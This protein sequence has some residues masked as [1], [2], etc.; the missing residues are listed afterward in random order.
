MNVTAR[1]IHLTEAGRVPDSLVRAGIRRLLRER[2]ASLPR[3]DREVL[4]DYRRGFIARMDA[5]PLAVMTDAA[6]EQHY[7]VPSDYYSLVLGPR[8]KYSSCHWGEGVATLEDAEQAALAITC[9]RAGLADGQRILELGCGW[10]SLSL[11]MAERYP[12]A[13]ITAVSNSHSQRA[14]IEARATA[15]GLAN[16]RVITADMNGFEPQG[17]FDRIVSV[18]MFEHMRNWRTLFARVADWLD[19][20]GRFFMH[21]FCHRDSPYFFEEESESDWMTR[22]FFRGGMMPSAD[23]PLHFQQHLTLLDQW[24]WNGIHYA[25]TLEAWL[26]RQDASEDAVLAVLAGHHGAEAPLWVTRWR[27]FYLACAEL[28]RMNGGNEWF[29]GHYLFEKPGARGGGRE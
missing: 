16:L 13:A 8:R 12:G 5:S 24:A 17:R 14:F 23:L 26:A 21:V 6:N 10:G 22:Y 29:V 27:L 11:W 9:Q 25:R 7:E 2:L 28:F 18:E 4:A 15:L 3:E 20:G 19:D 1:L